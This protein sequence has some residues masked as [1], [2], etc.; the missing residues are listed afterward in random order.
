LQRYGKTSSLQTKCDK[1]S[2]CCG[3]K[4]CKYVENSKKKANMTEMWHNS[5]NCC[6]RMIVLLKNR[7]R[8]GKTFS[9]KF[10]CFSLTLHYF[11]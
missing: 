7:Q 3:K 2:R 11:Q 10:E 6:V 8:F 5:Q 1:N 4:F 9:N